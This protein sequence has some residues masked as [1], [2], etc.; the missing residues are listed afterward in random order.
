MGKYTKAKDSEAK[1]IV[2]PWIVASLGL[3]IKDKV[4]MSHCLELELL[5]RY[6]K[7][8]SVNTLVLYSV[9]FS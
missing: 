5:K 2:V 6:A 8:G 4:S 7:I 1:K 3:F 9:S